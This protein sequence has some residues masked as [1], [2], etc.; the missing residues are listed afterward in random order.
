MEDLN[1]AETALVHGAG[2]LNS[3]TGWLPKN[4]PII[5]PPQPTT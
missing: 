3:L 2:A 4:V 5:L 1:L